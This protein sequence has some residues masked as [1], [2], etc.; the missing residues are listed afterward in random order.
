MMTSV[1]LSVVA[2]L[3]FLS[4]C[5]GPGHFEPIQPDQDKEALLYLYR[6]KADNPGLQPLR[7]SYPDILINDDSVGVLSFN[8]YRAIKVTPGEHTLTVTGLTKKS[9]WEPR[10]KALKF[11]IQA[12]ETKYIKL[13]I[14][15]D[16]KKMN[17]AEPSA[18]YLIYLTP[19][20]VESAIYEIRETSEQ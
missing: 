11:K 8:R 5:S 3:T 7:R 16:S 13:S 19:M 12:G 6:P 2:L 1:K 4:A 15:F 14:N 17:L 18:K 9:K 20:K 10:D